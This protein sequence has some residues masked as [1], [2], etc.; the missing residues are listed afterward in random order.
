M[1][2]VRDHQFDRRLSE[3]E[4]HS[5][6]YP[7]LTKATQQQTRTLPRTTSNITTTFSSPSTSTERETETTPRALQPV[8]EL[9]PSRV[10]EAE[11]AVLNKDDNNN[12]TTAG[13][14]SP[15]LST[16]N[17]THAH[18]PMRTPTQNT[19]Q[20]NRSGAPESPM[21]LSSPPA[22]IRQSGCNNRE[23]ND[24]EDVRR[25]PSQQGDAVDGLL[26]LMNTAEKQSTWSG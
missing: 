22:S 26:K 21:Q 15:P 6:K 16:D 20:Q 10:E 11:A 23:D 3:L 1:R 17:M 25:T 14:S 13:L 18:D 24:T 4:A 5:R 8:P 9:K 12:A 19:Y 7:R 2:H